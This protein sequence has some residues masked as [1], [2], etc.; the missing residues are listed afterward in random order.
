MESLPQFKDIAAVG[1]MINAILYASRYAPQQLAVFKLDEL[2]IRDT[3]LLTSG[4]LYQSILLSRSILDRYKGKSY[5]DQFRE[6]AEQYTDYRPPL[7]EIDLLANRLFCMH[8]VNGELNHPIEAMTGKRNLFPFAN[9]EEE[10]CFEFALICRPE[11]RKE[12]VHVST[13]DEL[14]E[15]AVED[16]VLAGEE[17]IYVTAQEIG[18][19]P[20]PQPQKAEL[21]LAA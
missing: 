15:S 10:K 21:K 11:D 3:I 5:T 4:L 14:I 19:K 1:K 13:L 16:F 7:V 18:L 20:V 8:W 2:P 12:G 9:K 17:F 6:I